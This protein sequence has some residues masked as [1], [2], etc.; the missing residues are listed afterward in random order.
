MFSQLISLKLILHSIALTV[1]S[2]FLRSVFVIELR[3][4]YPALQSRLSLT[5]SFILLTFLE[6]KWKDGI[7]KEDLLYYY[8][9]TSEQEVLED[10][11]GTATHLLSS[12]TDLLFTVGDTED[13]NRELSTQLGNLSMVVYMFINFFARIQTASPY[14]TQ[15]LSQLQYY[16]IAVDL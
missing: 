2:E 6:H 7:L 14:M 16:S 8:S 4:R 12:L 5:R 9:S 11:H 15:L 10:L 3:I 13:W 1:K